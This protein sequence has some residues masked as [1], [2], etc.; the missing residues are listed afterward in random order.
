[1]DTRRFRIGYDGYARIL[2]PRF[3]DKLCGL[4]L[5]FTGAV[6]DEILDIE[7]LAVLFFEKLEKY[8]INPRAI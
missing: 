6:K 3:D 5:A 8:P 2:W 4:Y 1:M 7:E